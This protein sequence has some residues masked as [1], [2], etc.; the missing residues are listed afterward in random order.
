M[1]NMEEELLLNKTIC[2][3]CGLPLNLYSYEKNNNRNTNEEE[4]II[5]LKC[6]HSAT[7][8]KYF[9]FQWYKKHFL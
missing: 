6:I 2:N 1:E 9:F 3:E 8:T 4:I 5:K 7:I